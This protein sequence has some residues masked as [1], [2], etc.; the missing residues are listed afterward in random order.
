MSKIYVLVFMTG[1]TG[2]V[3]H[4][5]GMCGPIVASY[6][7]ALSSRSFLPHLLYGFGRVTTYAFLGATLGLIRYIED[8]FTEEVKMSLL[9]Y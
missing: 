1:L 5:V 6:S 2:G 3:G 9:K 4:C 8:V 7:I